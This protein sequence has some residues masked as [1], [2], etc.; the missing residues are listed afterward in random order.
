MKLVFE[1][2]STAASVATILTLIVTVVP[3]RITFGRRALEEDSR[4]ASEARAKS[5][6][7]VPSGYQQIST[8]TP[9]SRR[10]TL[11][12]TAGFLAMALAFGTLAA[13]TRR[14]DNR[15]DDSVVMS[16]PCQ[17]HP[18]GAHDGV[19]LLVSS[20][21]AATSLSRSYI[22]E[23]PPP[24]FHYVRLDIEF[25]VVSGEHLVKPY[26]DVALVDS[27]GHKHFITEVLGADG[28]NNNLGGTTVGPGGQYGPFS[29]CFL[30]GDPI[31]AP[32]AIDWQDEGLRGGNRSIRI[33]VQ[34]N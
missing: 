18:C 24:G 7:I 29:L 17:P 2:L 14:N 26:D 11:G 23:S 5:R 6:I 34:T 12:L 33:P 13:I 4:P 9:R 22:T 31:T 10:I 28:C 25:R 21:Q 1:I 30:A 32:M 27:T 16:S 8:V 20:A 3:V 19:T 15:P